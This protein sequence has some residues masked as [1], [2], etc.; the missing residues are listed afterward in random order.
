[1][2]IEVG[3]RP[4]TTAG[5]GWIQIQKGQQWARADNKPNFKRGRQRAKI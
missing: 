2:E 3:K 4:T 5:D 1:M